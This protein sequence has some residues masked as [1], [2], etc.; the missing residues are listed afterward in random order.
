MR[1]TAVNTVY[2]LTGTQPSWLRFTK[3]LCRS[4][5][6]TFIVASMIALFAAQRPAAQTFDFC[7][8]CTGDSGHC[9]IPTIAPVSGTNWQDAMDEVLSRITTPNMIPF[10]TDGNPT[11]WTNGGVVDAVQI[12]IIPNKKNAWQYNDWMKM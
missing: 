6:V 12:Q 2:L 4:Y 3:K 10:L 7:T 8:N 5:G 1:I 9:V 11:G